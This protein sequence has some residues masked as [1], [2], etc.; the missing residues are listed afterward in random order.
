MKAT[1]TNGRLKVLVVDD[2]PIALEAIGELIESRGFE[3]HRRDRALGTSSWILRERPDIV[4]TDVNMPG[5][6]GETIL[7]VTRQR[8]GDRAPSFILLSSM[9]EA[10]LA[11]LS[12]RCGAVGFLRKGDSD[13]RTLTRFGEMADEHR[14]RAA[15]LA[16]H[17]L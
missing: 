14:Q 10:E 17:G 15:A 1:Q 6:G 13:S 5:V 3:V 9:P 7:E 2:D 12:T 16:E 8:M 4:V 11:A